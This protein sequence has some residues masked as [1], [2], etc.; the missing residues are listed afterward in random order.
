MSGRVVIIGHVY[1]SRLSIIRSVA[2]TGCEIIVIATSTPH[3]A[4]LL[5]RPVDSFSKYVSRFFYCDRKD[6]ESLVR[7][8]KERCAVPGQ[9]VVVIPDG[10]DIVAALDDHRDELKDAFIFPYFVSEPASMRYWMEKTNQKELAKQV[11]L[12]VA[13]GQ[14]IDI[15]EGAYSIPP[16]IRYPCFC[17]PLATKV[18][19]KGGM[20]KCDCREDLTEALEYIIQNRNKT[21]RV[22]VE[23]YKERETEYALMGFSDGKEVIVPGILEF[24]RESR[25]HTGIALQG[26]IVPVGGFEDLVEKF[27]S[28]VR[29]MGFVGMFDID[30]FKS[31]GRFYFCEMNLRFGGS[32][33][34]YTRMG[35]NLPAM[36][37]RSLW[38]ETLDNYKKHIAGSAVFVNERM[39][40]DDFSM[41]ALSWREYRSLQK[42]SGIC[43]IPDSR[44][45]GPARMYSLLAWRRR[46]AR[47]LKHLF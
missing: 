40:L 45:S 44:D 25:A 5:K 2:E 35:V 16:D 12:N 37:A 6:P 4:G 13:E 21:E 11:G 46:I 38:G 29:R 47:E 15:L 17:K 7:L 30:F 22:L 27:K 41:G 34:A 32:G 23:D 1:L 36:M 10:D 9:K 24:L 42:A 28:L 14:V 33:Y 31:G 8:L 39:C 3:A 18:G 43:F 20:R 26:R 19:G